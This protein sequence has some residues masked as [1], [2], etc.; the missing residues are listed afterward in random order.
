[1]SD[2]T[3]QPDHVVDRWLTDQRRAMVDDL[4][5]TLDLEAGL[6]EVMIPARHADL[7]ADLR[8]VLD[9]EDGLSAIVP[10]IPDDSSEVGPE[11]AQPDLQLPTDLQELVRAIASASPTARLAMRIRPTLAFDRARA[12]VRELELACHLDFDRALARAR[13]LV[14][15]LGEIHRAL[16]DFTGADLRDA[17]LTGVSLEGLRWSTTTKWPPD[18]VEQIELDSVEVEPGIFEVRGGTTYA[19][20]TV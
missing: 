5:A 14:S 4:A 6:R 17:D 8:D 7:V 15:V 19:P 2:P 1:M 11:E 16:S 10:A 3:S 12:L 13:N 18:W 9:V 20:T